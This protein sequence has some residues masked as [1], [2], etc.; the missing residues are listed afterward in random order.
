MLSE[1]DKKIAQRLRH[2]VEDIVDIL[3]FKVYGSRVRGDFRD[4]SDL[5]IFIEVE[6]ITEQKRKRLHEA[7]WKIGFDANRVIAILIATREQVEEGA[8]GAN[9]ILQFIDHEGVAV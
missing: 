6:A 4:E 3:D 5:D 9:P 2:V 1:E 7:A 8:F